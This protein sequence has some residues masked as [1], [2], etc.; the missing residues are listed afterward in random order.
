MVSD[1]QRRLS[2]LENNG[3][4]KD[5]GPLPPAGLTPY[6]NGPSPPPPQFTSPC[7]P[8]PAASFPSSLPLENPVDC[9]QVGLQ[10]EHAPH[11]SIFSS[12]PTHP[13]KDGKASA[14]PAAL[15]HPSCPLI[16]LH[17]PFPARTQAHAAPLRPLCPTS[18]TAHLIIPLIS[19]TRTVGLE[20]LTKPNLRVVRH[21]VT[22]QPIFNP[23]SAPHPPLRPAL[24][25]PIV[26]RMPPSDPESKRTT[27]A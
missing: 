15:R 12:Q 4:P 27:G 21:G 26:S 24:P 23:G 17:Q 11:Y 14:H 7:Y 9:A 1:L 19:P 13:E 3:L 25:T 20:I 10:G 2:A 18:H 6:F 22:V 5:N 8:H 16:R